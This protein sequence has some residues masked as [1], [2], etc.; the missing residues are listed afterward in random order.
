MNKIKFSKNAFDHV[1]FAAPARIENLT[2]WTTASEVRRSVCLQTFTA[3]VK[4]ALAEFFPFWNSILD[5]NYELKI[6]GRQDFP[7]FKAGSNF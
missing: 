6:Y 7:F 2:C 1:D 5:F 3:A 4:R